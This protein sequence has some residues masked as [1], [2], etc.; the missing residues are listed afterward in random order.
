M[1]PIAPNPSS[2]LRAASRL[3][4]V[5][6][7]LWTAAIVAH[8]AVRAAE[9]PSPDSSS[10]TIL[11]AI[12][13]LESEHDAKCHSTASRFEDFLFGTPLSA[14]ARFAH[15]ESK[16]RVARQLWLA[17]S[18]SALQSADATIEPRHIDP[19]AAELVVPTQGN[20]GRVRL[21]FAGGGAVALEN[22]RIEQYASIAYSLRA[23]LAVEQERTLWRGDPL[24][25]LSRDGTHALTQALDLLSLAALEFADRD[26]R[27]RNDFEVA[28][29]SL[30]SAWT[31]VAPGPKG[32]AGSQVDTALTS[33]ADLTI[34]RRQSLALLERIAAG[35][36][37]AYQRYNDLDEG[38]AA[39]LLVFN[40]SRF[41]ARQ[42]LS[43]YR[44]DRRAFVAVF[45]T[46]LDAFA[47]LLLRAADETARAAGHRL[48]R[49]ADARDAML[50]LVPQQIDEFEDVHVFPR[51]PADE[52]VTL[53]A[54]DCDSLR[55]FG[56]HWH[57]L[58]G[59]A[60]TAPG[61][62]RLP[63]PIAAEI[64][65]ETISQYGVLLLRLAGEIADQGVEAVRLQPDHLA[66]AALVISDRARR[67][68]AGRADE[69]P[70]SLI[71]S[72]AGP[73]GEASG[74]RFFTDVT[75]ATGID[76]SHH[77][78]RWLGEFRHRLLK[79]PPT[80]SGG[81]VAAEDVD[82]DGDI[83]LLFVG[84]GG[85]A[86]YLNDGS[87]RFTDVT[88]QASLDALRPDGTHGEPRQPIFA[89]FD[90]DGRTDLLITYVDDDHRLYR[91]LGAA[92]FED[93]SRSSGLGGKGL[94]AG[95][96]TVFDF[97]GDGL[98]DIYVGYFGDY[99][100]GSIPTFDRD[101]QNALPN[102][103][104]RNLGNFR[105]KDVTEGSGADDTGWTQAVS[106][107]DFDRDGRQDL[108]V[109]NDYGRNAF[110]RNLGGGRFENVT[111][112]LG[113]TKA[114]HSMNVGIADLNDDDYPDIY[115]SNLATLVKD[116]KYTFPDGN[117]PLHFDLRAMAGMLIKES[118]VLY[119]SQ[120]RG[121]RLV[122]YAPS[123]DVE[124]GATSTG[125]AWDAEFL[126]F[127]HDGD[128]DLYVVNG[129]NDFN[130]FS[131]V[132]RRFHDDGTTTEH[133][134]DHSRESNVFFRNEGG[135]LVNVSEESGADFV[136][137]SRSAVY[138]DLE[139]DGDLDIAV[140]NFHGR[141]TV[142]R[143]DAELQGGWL[144][145][146]LVGDPERSTNRD[147]IGARITVITADGARRHRE[148]Q[149]GSGYL[150]CD[151]KQQ[152]V[153][154][155][156]FAQAQV[157]ITWP[158]G[159]VETVAGLAANAAHELRQGHAGAVQSNGK[160]PAAEVASTPRDGKPDSK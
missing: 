51:L 100:A 155:G 91:N 50:R 122:A 14:R 68:P 90:N 46:R 106:H 70:S 127:D 98:I 75:S 115:I 134:L 145:L 32:T 54:F 84:G 49:A 20:D 149:G 10:D 61:G 96:A 89:D 39:K 15:E 37:S 57:S 97:D 118:N 45:R 93:V 27:V 62:Q 8:G 71:V 78:S 94:V 119:M 4:A 79:T 66:T 120:L 52:R 3:V 157:R 47:A 142:L 112:A 103:L 59:A 137:N 44:A 152:H 42:P 72:A 133:L 114:F 104:F 136:A 126:D 139:G 141:A 123:T 135:K 95:P 101:N 58:V 34:A 129:T 150:S 24:R 40:I 128:D 158:N 29:R 113:M 117:T 140:N 159:E 28:E 43:R 69:P 26:A 33:A 83:D 21:E 41:Y 17:A 144:K 138:F 63:D 1:L 74:G 77:S 109:A 148:V 111:A 12:E 116:D 53:E 92:R 147:A 67:H 153:G 80:F 30:L 6:L 131:M 31:R 7:A 88:Q 5:T 76:F 18:R 38:E 55:D 19:A 56:L 23:I 13:Q 121:E 124:R 108:I 73:A 107:T 81:G 132:Y 160:P 48:I 82:N 22:R 25:P 151:P 105:F 99:L 143:N 16:K 130:T 64:L 85:N 156:G 60:R 146:R 102:R 36:I 11:S 65:A 125:W 110:L 87:G 2:P 154:L 9:D 86:L 35:K